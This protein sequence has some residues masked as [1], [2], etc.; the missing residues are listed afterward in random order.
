[1]V[2]ALTGMK[3][4]FVFMMLRKLTLSNIEIQSLDIKQDKIV[5]RTI[6]FSLTLFAVLILLGNL[7]QHAKLDVNVKL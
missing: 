1:M 4:I 3:G 2:T 6:T 7:P 5:R